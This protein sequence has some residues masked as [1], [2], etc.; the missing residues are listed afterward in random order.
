VA[1]TYRADFNLI[2]VPLPA[3]ARSISLRYHDPAVMTGRIITII[4]L[5]VALAALGAGLAADRRPSIA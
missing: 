3:G 4:A 2:G 1:P 5:L